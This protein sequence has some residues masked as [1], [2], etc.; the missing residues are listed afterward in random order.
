[1][2]KEISIEIDDAKPLPFVASVTLTAG[3]PDAAARI[4]KALGVTVE[5]QLG[6]RNAD[7][8]FR[9]LRDACGA[10]GIYVVLLGDLGRHHTNLGEDLFRGLVISGTVAPL[11][12]VNDNDAPTARSFTLVHELAHLW[13]GRVALVAHWMVCRRPCWNDLQR[14]GFGLS[15][16]GGEH[17]GF[18]PTSRE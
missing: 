16:A 9:V 11:I 10:I 12:V 14:G 7:A 2:S 17:G 1:M 5:A 8:L 18:P 4:R 13:L 15:A 6:A 3:A